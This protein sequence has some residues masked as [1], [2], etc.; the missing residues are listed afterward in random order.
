MNRVITVLCFLCLAVVE[1]GCTFSSSVEGKPLPNLTFEHI[2]PLQVNVRD[3]EII[4]LYD[5]KKDSKDI[6]STFP[7]PP[8]IAVK[9]YA[10][11][12]LQANGKRGALKFIIEDSYIHHRYIES[13]GIVSKWLKLEGKDRYDV[14]MDIR[15]YIEYPDGRQSPHSVLKTERYISIPE[16]V[17]IAEREFEQLGFIER[18]TEDIDQVVTNGLVRTLKVLNK[19][20]ITGFVRS[21]Q[22]STAVLLAAP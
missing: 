3:I 14:T 12:R 17:S 6:S 8:D 1:A 18:L 22:P 19:E 15:F 7:T 13:E 16:S 21:G 9:R 4:N 11:N 2:A 5:P 20:D 10:E